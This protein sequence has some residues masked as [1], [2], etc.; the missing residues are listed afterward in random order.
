MSKLLFRGDVSRSA[1][2]GC[3]QLGRAN[4]VVEC[5]SVACSTS[6]RDI[7]MSML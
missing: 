5:S 6:S 4:P 2:P 1:R 3:T 7:Y